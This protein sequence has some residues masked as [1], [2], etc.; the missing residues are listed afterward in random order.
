MLKSDLIKLITAHQQDLSA[1]DIKICVDIILSQMANQLAN[2]GRIEIRDFGNLSL[3]HHDARRAHNPKT[4]QTLMT[5]P[6]YAVHFKM[7]KGMK[8]RLNQ[9]KEKGIPIER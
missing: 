3:K 7:G 8:N 5:K 6:K 4:G 1:S 2:K 9:A